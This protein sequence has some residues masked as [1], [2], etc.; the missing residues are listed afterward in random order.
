MPERAELRVAVP[1]EGKQVIRRA[2][3]IQGQT[4][5]GFVRQR[6]LPK[7]RQVVARAALEGQGEGDS[8]AGSR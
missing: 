6:T 7:A 4:I 8:D 2:A 1:Q 3:E 5:S